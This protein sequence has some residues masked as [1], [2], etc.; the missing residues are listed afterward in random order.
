MDKTTKVGFDAVRERFSRYIAVD[1]RSDPQ[2]SSETP[3]S[4]GQFKLA[5]LLYQELQDMGLQAYLDQE[6][7]YTYGRLPGNKAG[8]PAIGFLAHLDTSPDMAGVT[9]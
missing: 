4:A 8:V 5:G 3:S 6:H 2:K 9:T 1:T 7:A